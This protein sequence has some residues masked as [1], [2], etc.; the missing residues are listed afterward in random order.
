MT[1]RKTAINGVLG[2]DKPAGLSSFDVIRKVRRALGIRKVGHTGTLDPMATG[3]L[4]LVLGQATRLAPFVV[5]GEKRYT[6]SVRFGVETN[7]F[8]AEGEVTHKASHESINALNTQRIESAL[9]LFRGEIMQ[10]P[11]VFS[12]IKVDGKRS[13]ARARNGEKF[14]LPE[15]AV[16]IHQLEVVSHRGPEWDFDIRCSKGTYIRSFASDLGQAVGT[17]AHLIGLRRTR[18]GSFHIDDTTSIEALFENPLEQLA[19]KLKPMVSAVHHLN[20]INVTADA[21]PGIRN[22]QAAHLGP[23]VPGLHRAMGPESEL[24]AILEVGKSGIPT[25]KRGFPPPST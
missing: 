10:R 19:Q 2:I 3:L 14:E 16:H 15:R 22:G 24:L 12:A 18:V 5:D 7:T 9:S 25:I 21:V 1:N 6:A 13:Y 8:D 23:L 17:G 11:P 4:V 20:P